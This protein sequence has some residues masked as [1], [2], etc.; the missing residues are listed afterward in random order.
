MSV[1]TSPKLLKVTLFLGA[2]AL[3]WANCDLVGLEEMLSNQE[4]QGVNGSCTHRRELAKQGIQEC[5]HY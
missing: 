1:K 3:M 2:K 4:I 5:G